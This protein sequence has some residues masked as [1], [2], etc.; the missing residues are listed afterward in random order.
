M[1]VQFALPV[2]PSLSVVHGRAL[3]I[4]D[5]EQAARLMGASYRLRRTIGVSLAGLLP[6]HDRHV[7]AE[8][9]VRGALD[10]RFYAAAF[11]EGSAARDAVRLALDTGR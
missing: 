2:Q 3:A 6:L 4:G 8:R 9:L 7:E 5:H 11:A 1:V 10:A